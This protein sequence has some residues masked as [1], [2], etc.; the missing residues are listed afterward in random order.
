MIVQHTLHFSNLKNAFWL[1]IDTR[2]TQQDFFFAWALKKKVICIT[3]YYTWQNIRY[4]S[5]ILGLRS[6]VPNIGNF[7]YRNR[8]PK[9]CAQQT[10]LTVIGLMGK[11]LVIREIFH[12]SSDKWNRK[13]PQ[14]IR[15]FCRLLFY[16][17]FSHL[18]RSVWQTLALN[19]L[20]L[21]NSI[22]LL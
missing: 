17:L 4:Q 9:H 15:S 20:K 7:R 13:F 5:R 18:T 1:G 11:S 12:F 21:N 3:I 16:L 8:V 2:Q 22:A 10:A 14:R 6:R 19:E